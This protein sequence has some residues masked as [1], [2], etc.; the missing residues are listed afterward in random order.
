MAHSG[1][2]K[3]ELE[4]L[5]SA[6]GDRMRHLEEDAEIRPCRDA[7]RS[8]ANAHCTLLGSRQVLL[9]RGTGETGSTG[10]RW[11]RERGRRRWRLLAPPRSGT[12]DPTAWCSGAATSGHLELMEGAEPPPALGT[13]REL[14]PRRSGRRGGRNGLRQ[15]RNN[16]RD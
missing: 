3:M 16:G 10:H 15:G 2:R 1:S 6:V 13:G 8:L 5:G 14:R 7:T 11:R 9:W 4:E 12:P